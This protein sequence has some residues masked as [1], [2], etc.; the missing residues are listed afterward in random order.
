MF[1]LPKAK[2]QGTHLEGYYDQS[3]FDREFRKF[4]GHAPRDKIAGR[5]RLV[6]TVSDHL[7]Q[8]EL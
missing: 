7:L 4:V 3:H 1:A 8:G 2:V 6:T 5:A